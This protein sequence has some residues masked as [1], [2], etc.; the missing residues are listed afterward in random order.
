[1]VNHSTVGEFEDS[2]AKL[3]EKWNEIVSGRDVIEYLTNEYIHKKEKFVRAYTNHNLYLGN[4]TSS[5]V[6]SA[7]TVLKKCLGGSTGNLYIVF[8]SIEAKL[9]KQ[10]IA[11]SK[12][13]SDELQLVSN[14]LNI[15]LL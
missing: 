11:A 6:E 2:W 5:Q 15:L 3:Q 4:V 12:K 1:M 7:Y 8:E 9:N 13:L 10:H 14:Q